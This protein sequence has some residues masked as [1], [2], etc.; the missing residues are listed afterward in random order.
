MPAALPKSTSPASQPL[1][2]VSANVPKL[3]PPSA[4][5]LYVGNL[6]DGFN[7]TTI[8]EIFDGYEM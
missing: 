6:D 2:D 3:P 8:R 5:D 1:Q 4:T 7:E